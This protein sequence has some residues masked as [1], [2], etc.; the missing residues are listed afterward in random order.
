[1][2]AA[3]DLAN[4]GFKVYLVEETTAIGGRMVQ[5]DKT[6]PT[7]ACSMCIISPKLIEVEKHLNIEIISNYRIQSLSGE[8]GNFAVKVLKKPRYIDIEKCSACGDCLDACP[9]D[10]SMSLSKVWPSARRFINAIPRPY[11]A[12]LR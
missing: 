5:L 2:Q 8:A 6:F 4:S 7:N 9:V 10:L 12:P 1:M 11:P 3:L